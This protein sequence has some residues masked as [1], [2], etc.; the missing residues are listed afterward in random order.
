MIVYEAT[1]S[2]FI[3]QVHDGL[4]VDR[5]SEKYTDYIGRTNKS[6]VR[7]WENSMFHM[8]RVLNDKDI[9]D[10]AG[11]A[12][13]FRIPHTS[14][15]VDFILSGHDGEQDSV[16]I[17]ELKQWDKIELIKGKEGIV[18]TRFQHGSPET[19]HPSYQAWS[20]AMLIEDYNE[21]VQK[22]QIQLH[23]C[24]YL[25]N[26]KINSENDPLIDSH[27]QYYIDKA[28]VYSKS[29]IVKLR[30]FV[31]KHI[32]YGDEKQLLYQIENGRIR[33]SKSLQDSLSNMLLGN[34]E[35]VLIDDQKVVF[36]TALQ[37]AEQA[38]KGDKKHVM[39][40][41]GG[42][43]TGKSVIAI[44]LLV[45]LTRRGFV[46]TYVTRAAAPREVYAANLKGTLTKGRVDNLFKG[47]GSF[48]STSLNE[49]DALIT[50]EA[51][52]LNEK[53]G[54]YQN[55]GENQIKEIIG[56]ANFSVTYYLCA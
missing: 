5:I 31:K 8:Y 56:A 54:M 24:A 29:D 45:E 4:I 46:S 34:R 11:V 41:E 48:T 25:H 33:P 19:P 30:D 26:Y 10:D 36:E 27:Y 3:S 2:E 14:K 1:K 55:L 15:R 9:P 22:Q 16:V 21:N 20:Y 23:P 17:V 43:G 32:K 53:S 35:F 50:D 49:Y 12:I 40:I 44:N 28:P 18:K 52:R 47:S 51:H 13:E 42:P 7:S 39:I 37:L 38:N 6:E